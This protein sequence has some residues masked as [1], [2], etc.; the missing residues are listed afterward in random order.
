MVSVSRTVNIHELPVPTPHYSH[1]DDFHLRDVKDFSFMPEEYRGYENTF[2]VPSLVSN[3]EKY[4]K[5][6]KEV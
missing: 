3:V 1:N 4:H 5:F 2:S 6:Y